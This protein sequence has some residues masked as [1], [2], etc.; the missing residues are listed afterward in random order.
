[1]AGEPHG[2]ASHGLASP[3][4]MPHSLRET[5]GKAEGRREEDGAWVVAQGV[6]QGRET[7]SG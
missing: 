1:M 5:Q 2:M 4:T 6:W 7:C 3:N